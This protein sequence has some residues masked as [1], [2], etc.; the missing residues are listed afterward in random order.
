[1]S[2]RKRLGELLV[3]AKVITPQQLQTALQAQMIYGGRLGTNLVELDYITEEFLSN[4][5]ASKLRIPCARPEELDSVPAE[6]LA[7]VDATTAQKY[8][9]IPLKKERKTLE[10]AMLDPTDLKALDELAFKTGCVLRPKVAAEML[11]VLA[12]ERLYGLPRKNRYIR[13]SSAGPAPGPSMAAG[14]AL[15]RVA[16]PAPDLSPPDREDSIPEYVGEI[17]QMPAAPSPLA[18]YVKALLDADSLEDISKAIVSMWDKHFDGKIVVFAPRGDSFEVTHATGPAGFLEHA[19]Q[20]K[21]ALTMR[22]TV[23]L[24]VYESHRTFRGPIPNDEGNVTLMHDLEDDPAAHA[25]IMPLVEMGR[26]ELMV[27]GLAPKASVTEP[28]LKFFDLLFD[29]A[30]IALQ[31]HRLK[32][33]LL[34]IPEV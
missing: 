16:P 21:V 15:A 2:G 33:R 26:V 28:T 5:L 13:I 1:M 18:L 19:K 14:P 20:V 24:Q 27:M 9:V 25:V 10:V 8:Q 17:E 6:V 31:I 11:V 12:L 30:R 7:L 4:F 29:K 22:P 32:R 34:R 23:V 3:E